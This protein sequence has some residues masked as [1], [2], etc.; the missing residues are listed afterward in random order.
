[1]TSRPH[2]L[3]V[4]VVATPLLVAAV[5]L[6]NRTLSTICC[7][8]IIGYTVAFLWR[9]RIRLSGCDLVVRG[10]LQADRVRTADITQVDMDRFAMEGAL[11]G[12]LPMLTVRIAV[13][14]HLGARFTPFFWHSGRTMAE[15]IRSRTQSRFS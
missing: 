15:S 10:A 4:V 5:L 7:S 12:L 6:P 13:G 1:M 8:S 11:L 9:G 2:A 3:R 14:G